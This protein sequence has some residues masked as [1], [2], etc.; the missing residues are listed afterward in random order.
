MNSTIQA[1]QVLTARS[2]C[3]YECIYEVRVIERKGSFVKV[4][5][6]HGLKRVKVQADYMGR[7]CIYA[8]G[9]FSMCPVFRAP[10]LPA[11]VITAS[12]AA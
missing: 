5:T 7:E 4:E 12:F 10:E 11:N 2:I 3:D 8:H 6:M 1:G 9:K